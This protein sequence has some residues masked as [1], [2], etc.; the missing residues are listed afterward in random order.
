[1]QGDPMV[2]GGVQDSWIGASFTEADARGMAER[3]GFE[4]RFQ[5]G[6][7]EQYYWLWFFKNPRQ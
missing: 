3:C 2:G 6:V 5:A 7:G 4:M 1:V